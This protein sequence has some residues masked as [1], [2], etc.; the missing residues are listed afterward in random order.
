MYSIASGCFLYVNQDVL[1][2]VGYTDIDPDIVLDEGGES[3]EIDMNDDGVSDFFFHNN[4]FQ[5]YD[6]S[7]LS[8]R[9]MKNILAGPVE[10]GNALAGISNYFNTGYNGFTW[11]YPFALEQNVTINEELTWQG[12]ET[13]IMGLRVF[14]EDGDL[15][16]LGFYCYWSETE[17]IDKYLG[18]KFKDLDDQIHYG[19]IRCDVLDEGR[20]LIIKDYAYEVEPEYPILAG[21]TIHYVDIEQPENNLIF[22]IYGFGNNIYVHCSD[23]QNAEIRIYDI[24]GK[25]IYSDN[26][27][28]QFTEIKL[29]EANGIYL[30]ELLTDNKSYTKKVFMN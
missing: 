24:S 10:V 12:T 26:L 22:S 30:V 18:V 8:F 20:T 11:Y 16:G 14:S 25:L 7:W 17:T 28:Y 23:P 13:Q 5:Y 27:I 19:W 1:G 6:T 4:S 2:Q 15:V 9:T 21:D 29:R 3:A